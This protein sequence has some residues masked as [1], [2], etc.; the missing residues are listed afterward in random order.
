MEIQGWIAWD[1]H[2]LIFDSFRETADEAATAAWQ[3][4]R[5]AGGQRLVGGFYLLPA[6]LTIRDEDLP[7]D[8]SYEKGDE[9]VME[10]QDSLHARDV[11]KSPQQ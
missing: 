5:L 9:T 8:Y 1:K 10:Q 3:F 11:L 6:T 2:G 4:L 7:I